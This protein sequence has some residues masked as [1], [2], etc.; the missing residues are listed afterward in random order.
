MPF[1]LLCIAINRPSSHLSPK[2]LSCLIVMSISYMAARYIATTGVQ[3]ERHPFHEV[4][5]ADGKFPYRPDIVGRPNVHH[6]ARDLASAHALACPRQICPR[7]ERKYEAQIGLTEMENQAARTVSVPHT[8]LAKW[9]LEALASRAES[10]FAHLRSPISV[11]NCALCRESMAGRAIMRR[12]FTVTGTN[13]GAPHPVYS[14]PPRPTVLT[15][16]CPSDSL[17]ESNVMVSLD[18]P[19]ESMG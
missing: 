18:S 11:A 13:P 16:H 17:A 2:Y 19:R 4:V 1:A 7:P 10:H 6:S 14:P 15:S 8:L 3:Q 12:V 5:R 9:R